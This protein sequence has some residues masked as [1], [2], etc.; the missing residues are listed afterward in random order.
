MIIIYLEYCVKLAKVVAFH[1]DGSNSDIVPDVLIL[2]V[3]TVNCYICL[4]FRIL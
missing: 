1:S 2:T 3:I 4:S